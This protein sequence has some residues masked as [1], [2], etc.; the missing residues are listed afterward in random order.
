M[1]DS[2]QPQVF[3]PERTTLPPDSDRSQ[4]VA[5]W[6]AAADLADELQLAAGLVDESGLPAA[7]TCSRRAGIAYL[8]GHPDVAL[9]I[10]AEQ[11]RADVPADGPLH[12]DHVLALGAR[13]GVGDDAA[14]A[15]L[16][17]VGGIVPPSHRPWFLYVLAVAAERVGELALAD[18][19]WRALAVDHGVQ[20]PLVQSRF[21]A[22]WVA[23]RDTRDADLA[24]GRV[25][26]AAGSLRASTPRPWDDPSVTERTVDALVL[27]G[28]PAGAALLAAAVVR[29][30]RPDTRLT[31]LSTRTRPEVH[32][33]PT[34]VPLLAAAVATIAA[35]VPGLILGLLVVRYLRLRW[36][37]IPSLTS[38]DERVWFGIAGLRFDARNERTSNGS[39]QVRGLIAILVL[40]GFI[41]GIAAGA[42]LSSLQSRWWPD[43]PVVVHVTMWLVSLVGLPLLGGYLGTRWARVEDVRTMHRRDTDEDRARL[44]GAASCRCWESAGLVGPFAGAYA[45]AHL[46]PSTEPGMTRPPAGRTT[47][48]LECPLSGVRWLA[49]TTESGISALLLRGTPRPARADAPVTGTG[50]YL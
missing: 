36:R 43:A 49:T 47:L 15:R 9:A 38:V 41:A 8:S 2:I 12:G 10:L 28:D 21:L 24:V 40:V 50:G 3:A 6:A 18:D 31:E 23:G 20:T 45:T 29:T 34:V 7:E 32:R 1:H 4:L 30:T 35:A 39:T 33:A 27:R 44:A 14:F 46:R 22:G 48:V 13:A 17:G 37:A 19:A 26:E 42:G 25:M 5:S 11:G 16:V